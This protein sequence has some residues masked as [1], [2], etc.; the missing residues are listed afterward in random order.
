MIETQHDKLRGTSDKF[1]GRAY[2]TFH[3]Y[4]GFC[5]LTYDMIINT[6]FHK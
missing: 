6:Q 1:V 5:E 2:S 3:L 4:Y